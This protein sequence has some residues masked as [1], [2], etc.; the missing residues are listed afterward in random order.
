M[1]LS[2]NQR[3]RDPQVENYW[4]RI[5]EG[6]EFPKQNLLLGVVAETGDRSPRMVVER[7]V[8]LRPV[9]ATEQSPS[10]KSKQKSSYPGCLRG[11]AHTVS[12]LMIHI[13]LPSS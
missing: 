13:C 2:F 7:G 12:S 6:K 11:S 5:I 3:G 9:W 1:K 4:C 10:Q 8:D